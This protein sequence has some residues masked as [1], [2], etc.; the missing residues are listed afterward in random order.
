M[1]YTINLTDGSIFATIA[2]GTINTSSSMTLVGKNYAGYGEFLDENFIH[3]LEN[4]SNTTAPGAPLTGQ[5][6]WDSG[7]G[8]L[9]VYSGTAW[10]RIGGA[11]AS[12][13]APSGATSEV[14]DLWYDTTNAQLKVYTGS[15]WLLVG[16]AFTSGTGTTGAIVD[17]IVDNTAVSHVV[18]KFFVEDSV[19]AIM[20]KDATFTPQSSIS[21]FT[22][23]RPGMTMATSV[24]GQTPL[25]QGT[26]TDSQLLDGID[27]TGFLSS[28]SNDTTSGTLG[29]LNDSGLSVGVDQDA[30]LSVSGAG[31]VTLAN[32]TSG[33]NMTFSVNVGGTPTT[34]LTIY[35]ANGTVAGN[36]VNANYADVAERFAAD[37][38]LE[39]GTVVE[40]GGLKEITKVTSDLSDNVFGVISTRAAYLMNSNAGGDETHPP[41][42][43]TGRVPVKVIGIVNKGD[44]LVS[45]GNGLARAAQPGEATA[46]NVIGRSLESKQN[47]DQGMVEA[48]VTI[49]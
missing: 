23:V 38:M 44:R 41:V 10:K 16:P 42:A 35:G 37:E 4:S 30:K 7:N 8:V 20:S 2:D 27:S 15:A 5:I 24:G 1:A 33:Q 46:F 39:A 12:A 43:M 18:I 32:Q 48:I 22:T 11:T 28:T 29:I 14:G 19:V 36:Q 6:W 45:A 40:L 13:T 25:F 31:V 17:T 47:Q 9:N 49:K 34:A 21:G 3:L 26:A